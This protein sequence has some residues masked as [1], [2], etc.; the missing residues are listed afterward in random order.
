MLSLPLPRIGAGDRLAFNAEV[1][2]TTTC[3]EELP[4]CIGRR[5]AFDPHIGARIFLASRQGARSGPATPVS[6]RVE[7]TCEQTR[8]NRNHHCPLI[9]DE[10]IAVGALS[11]LPCQPRRCRLNLLVD[12]HHRKREGGEVVL[13]GADQPDGDVEPGKAR[14][15]AVVTK[16]GAKVN[17]RRLASGRR[18]TRA[19][20][21]FGRGRVVLSQRLGRL[22]A[23]DLL[24]VQ[25]AQRVRVREL[26][27]F[28]GAKAIVASEP[29]SIKPGPLARRIVSRKG[30]ATETN[31][32]NCT[33]GPSAFR[34]PCRTRKVGLAALERTPKRDGERVPLYV[35]LVLRSFPKVAQQRGR[36]YPP[37]R[38]LRGGELKVKRLRTAD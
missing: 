27:Y 26:P 36:S 9:L 19:L 22:E 13:M 1:T 14:L 7:L 8:P 5:Y 35:N 12:A 38:V 24:L 20:R 37:A 6:R 25:A 29:D 33:I 21:A 3:V 2:V 16:A 11:E 23:G 17:E 30:T 10:E 31:G 4:R 34:S 15:S 18:R 32:F 28:V